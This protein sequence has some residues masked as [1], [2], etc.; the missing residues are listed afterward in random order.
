MSGNCVVWSAGNA[1]RN[2]E[3][4][5]R[6]NLS[7]HSFHTIDAE[8]LLWV[9]RQSR[10]WEYSCEQMLPCSWGLPFQGEWVSVMN[11]Q[12][13]NCIVCQKEEDRA[14]SGQRKGWAGTRREL[15]PLQ[16]PPAHSVPPTSADQLFRANPEG[17]GRLSNRRRGRNECGIHYRNLATHRASLSPLR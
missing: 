2:T 8:Y 15:V 3:R 17:R 4:R 14:G 7:V 6:S 1:G 5:G 9:R 16:S 12:R 13:H 10:C 11:K